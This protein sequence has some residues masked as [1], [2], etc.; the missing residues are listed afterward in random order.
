[1]LDK[2]NFL[3]DTLLSLYSIDGAERVGFVTPN[4]FE[5]VVNVSPDPINSMVV[6][7]SDVLKYTEEKQATATWHTHPNSTCNLS[8]EDY[9]MFKTWA[10]LYHIIIG[11]EG[12][13]VYKFDEEKNSVMEVLYVK[14]S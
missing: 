14:N 9:G 10:D 12:F 7:P 11:K 5:E 13:K 3:R 2:L 6:S 8:G 1:M 4:S